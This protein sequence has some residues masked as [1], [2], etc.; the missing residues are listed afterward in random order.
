MMDSEEILRIAAGVI[1][2]IGFAFYAVVW[3]YILRFIAA[4]IKALKHPKSAREIMMDS[5]GNIARAGG[6]YNHPCEGQCDDPEIVLNK[7]PTPMY[8]HNCRA[9]CATATRSGRYYR[10]KRRIQTW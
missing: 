7:S 1:L 4:V 6:N 8:K 2:F 10:G 3:F 9:P 5:L